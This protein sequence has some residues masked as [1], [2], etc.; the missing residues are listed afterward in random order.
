LRAEGAVNA[1]CDACSAK[2]FWL[3]RSRH[4]DFAAHRKTRHNAVAD[5]RSFGTT[6]ALEVA[7]A[8]ISSALL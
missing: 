1:P 8:H 3:G 4:V 2:I 5:A 6:R 7:K